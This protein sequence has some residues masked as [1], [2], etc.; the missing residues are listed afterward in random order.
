MSNILRIIAEWKAI[1]T[2][3][4]AFV[5]CRGVAGI[6]SDGNSE[7]ARIYLRSAWRN[8][9]R[10]KYD[11]PA[12]I[13]IRSG[14]LRAS[15]KFPRG[16]HAWVAADPKRIA[17]AVSSIRQLYIRVYSSY[18]QQTFFVIGEI[19]LTDNIDVRPSLGYRVGIIRFLQIFPR[20]ARFIQK[21]LKDVTTCANVSWKWSGI[22]RGALHDMRYQQFAWMIS[23]AKRH[24]LCKTK[25]SPIYLL[26]ER[27]NA[28]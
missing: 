10:S 21:H 1:V 15:E 3:T 14:G 17:E 19:R 26:R 18:L 5:V 25:L 20:S 4:T 24:C 13:L 2:A 23:V 22:I 8:S 27:E 16:D 6:N 12:S 9:S 28:W 11:R 7:L